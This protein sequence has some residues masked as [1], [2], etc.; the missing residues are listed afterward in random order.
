MSD[1]TILS[2]AEL[3]AVSGGFVLVLKGGDGGGGGGASN[4]A[5]IGSGNSAG[6]GSVL[7]GTVNVVKGSYLSV[8]W[9]YAAGGEGGDGGAGVKI[10]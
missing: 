9:S 10:S 5:T 6:Y 3:D 2:D 7:S 8:N 4:G 1:L